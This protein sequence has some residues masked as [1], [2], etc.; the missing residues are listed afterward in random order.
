[1]QGDISQS[2]RQPNAG[3]ES[4]G[5]EEEG[6]QHLIK[7]HSWS[8]LKTWRKKKKG[9]Y[10]GLNKINNQEDVRNPFCATTSASKTSN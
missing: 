9:A 7:H 2:L 4:R 6:Q 3:E 8:D 5:G 10:E 1:M